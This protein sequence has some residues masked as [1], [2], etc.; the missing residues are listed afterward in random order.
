[1]H[2]L[3]GIDESLKPELINDFRS[4]DITD[5]DLAMLEYVEKITLE[6]AKITNDDID[7]L[8]DTG[9]DKKGIHDIAQ[10]ASYFNYINRLADSLGIEIEE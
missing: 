1:L 2:S 5:E 9:Y 4:A 7:K 8:L 3:G 6:P 10:V